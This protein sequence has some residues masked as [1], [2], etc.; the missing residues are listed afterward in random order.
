MCNVWFIFSSALQVGIFSCTVTFHYRPSLI[1]ELGNT[2]CVYVLRS[3]VTGLCSSSGG[4]CFPAARV[5]YSPHARDVNWICS[6]LFR[7]PY[8]H[9]NC[10]FYRAEKEF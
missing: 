1:L 3:P 6:D 8:R 4:L 7:A 2:C 5:V 10:V 9:Y